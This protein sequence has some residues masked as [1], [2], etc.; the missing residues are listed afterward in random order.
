MP[1]Y[2]FISGQIGL[3]PSSLTLPSPSVSPSAPSSSPSTTSSTLPLETALVLQHTARI[4][5]AAPNSR[6]GNDSKGG[7][8]ESDSSSESSVDD[9][10][11]DGTGEEGWIQLAIYYLV[12]VADVDHVRKNVELVDGVCLPRPRPRTT[13]IL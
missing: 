3:I 13:L 8:G 9:V 11:R 1:P 12:H 10:S 7:F 5:R 2:T 4:I 6:L